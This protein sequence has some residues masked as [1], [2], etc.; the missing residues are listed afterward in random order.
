MHP[1]TLLAGFL[2]LGSLYACAAP[3]A[4]G[5]AVGEGRAAIVGGSPSS[6]AEDSVVLI[7]MTGGGFCSGTLIAP[8]LVLTARHC[9][10]NL[11]DNTGAVTS[12][13]APASLKIATGVSATPAK[14]TVKGKRVFHDTATTLEGH[15]LSLILLEA[16]VPGAKLSEVRF[17]APVVAEDTVAVGY[18]DNGNGQVTPGRYRRAGVKVTSVGP[19][20]YSFKPKTGASIP[21]DVPAG[22]FATG[23]STCFG[24]S[25]GP[26]FDAQGR[27]IGVT[28][29]GIDDSCLDRP[30]LFTSAVAMKALID[31]AMEVA[32]PGGSKTSSSSS[33]SSPKDEGSSSGSSGRTTSSSSGGGDD[34][35]EEATPRSTSPRYQSYTQTSSCAASPAS[36]GAGWLGFGLALGFGVLLAGRRRRHST[37]V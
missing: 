14:A 22:D 29:R 35:E 30:S 17:T 24:D 15:D 28:S 21:V 13:M 9:V 2:A 18:G 10:S 11:D 31:E 32:Q 27:V 34:E 5:E 16:D 4:G 1:R 3:S 20:N 23:E 7:A 37:D 25:G 6:A 19:A 36:A 33:G 12:D 26:L 8:N